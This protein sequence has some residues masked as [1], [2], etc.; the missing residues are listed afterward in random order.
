MTS[1]YGQYIK[2][3][4]GRGIVEN[5]EGFATFDYIG[6]D[7]VYIVD[8]YVVPEKRKE[9]IA[10]KLAD[11]I[12]EQ[13]VKDGK[14]HLLGSVDVTAKGAEASIAVLKAYGMKE[15][16][17]VEPMIFFNKQIAPLADEVIEVANG[18][19]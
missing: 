2:E 4:A 12:V 11:V 17:V 13:A 19:G 1:L 9:G 14:K 7:V 6:E 8:L 16:K 5:D 10:S 3:R 18:L 15:Y